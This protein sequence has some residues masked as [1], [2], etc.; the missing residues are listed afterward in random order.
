MLKMS[1]GEAIG[2]DGGPLVG[3][4]FHICA[5]HVDHGLDGECHA[6]FE[7]WSAPA[8]TEIWH[9]G[10]LVKFATDAV[11]DEFAHDAEAIFNGFGF[12]KI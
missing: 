8:F 5:A 9:L 3:E 4:N 6:G 12:H 2:S 10:I 7:F 1:G 11:A